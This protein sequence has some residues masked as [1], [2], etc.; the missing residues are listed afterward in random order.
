[1]RD[2]LF[3]YAYLATI[4]HVDRGDIEEFWD[5]IVELSGIA[6]QSEKGLAQLQKLLLYIF[7]RVEISPGEIQKP[8]ARISRQMEAMVMTTAE[9][10][11]EQGKLEGKIEG[12]LEGKLDA[13]RRLLEL[14]VP[15]DTVLKATALSADDLRRV[16]GS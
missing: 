14:N 7:R 10:L 11:I 15:L 8:L 1:M 4:L 16:S 3:L 13:A 5:G 2:S 6:F 12:K 9:K